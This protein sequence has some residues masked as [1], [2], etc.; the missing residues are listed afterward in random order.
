MAKEKEFLEK[1]MGDEKLRAEVEAAG[2]QEVVRIAAEAGFDIDASELEKEVKRSRTEADSQPVLLSDDDMD[3][4][5]GGKLWC[6]EDAP[7]GHEM[8]CLLIYHDEGYQLRNRVYCKRDYY[9]ADSYY[10]GDGNVGGFLK[11][12]D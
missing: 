10:I 12:P 4:V 1:L 7:D 8:G 5:A 9:C 3:K 2:P 11:N 6:G